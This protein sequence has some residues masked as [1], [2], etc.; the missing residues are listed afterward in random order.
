MDQNQ[1][2]DRIF[3]N[4]VF[5]LTIT[6]YNQRVNLYAVDKEFF[7]VYYDA[8]QNEIVK[9][10]EVIGEDLNKYLNRIE[11]GRI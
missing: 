8:D 2:A 11:V 1:L 5:L 6:Y 3:N 4:G 7:E 10:N 9:L